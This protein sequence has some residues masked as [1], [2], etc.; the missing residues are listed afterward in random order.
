MQHATIFLN[1]IFLKGFRRAI[2]GPAVMSKF[3]IFEGFPYFREFSLFSKG[4]FIFE[5]FSHFRGV[6]SLSRGFFIFEG[7]QGDFN[8]SCR[9]AERIFV[10]LIA[11]EFQVGRMIKNKIKMARMPGKKQKENPVGCTGEGKR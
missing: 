9:N 5:G 3:V 10:L 8:W 4:F 11:V 7:F 6:S 2:I 1:L